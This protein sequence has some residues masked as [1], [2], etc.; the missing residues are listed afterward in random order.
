VGNFVDAA[1]LFVIVFACQPIVKLVIVGNPLVV[2]A[3]PVAH[4]R[5]VHNLGRC[6][7]V[8]RFSFILLQD[9]T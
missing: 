4:Q 8:G 2:H 3:V 6:T 5:V 7:R 9:S 1:L